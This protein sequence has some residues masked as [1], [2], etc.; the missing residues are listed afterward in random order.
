MY[1]IDKINVYSVH[2]VPFFCYFVSTTK[3]SAL[4]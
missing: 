1:T 4:G 3:M 2:Y